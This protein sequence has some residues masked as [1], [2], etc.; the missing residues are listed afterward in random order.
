MPRFRR[1]PVEITAEQWFPGK[2][3]AGVEDV[4]DPDDPGEVVGRVQTLEGPIFARA[5]DW[6]VTGVRGEH[7]PVK[8]HIFD[9]IYEPVDP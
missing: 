9:E 5:G 1:K 6:I 8:P 4:P 3:V 2:T 7:Y